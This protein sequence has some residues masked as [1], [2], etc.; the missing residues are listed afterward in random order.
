MWTRSLLTLLAAGTVAATAL[1]APAAAAPRVLSILG[2]LNEQVRESE[3]AVLGQAQNNAYP[4]PAT[5]KMKVALLVGQVYHGPKLPPKLVVNVKPGWYGGKYVLPTPITRGQW[6]LFFCRSEGGAWTAPALGRVVETPYQGLTF[7]PDH[8]VVLEDAAPGLSWSFVLD[9]L[10]QLVATRKQI[11]G[12]YMPR[13][14]KAATKEQ[15]DRIRWT[16]EYEVKDHL[17]LPVP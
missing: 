16:I 7:Y 11:M 5:G 14:R 6:I 17:G 2:W 13:L 3:M 1:A 10:T 15:Q 4:D 9:S 8:D 12:G